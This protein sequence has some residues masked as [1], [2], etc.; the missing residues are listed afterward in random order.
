VSRTVCVIDSG[1]TVR[2]G[3]SVV[4]DIS[5]RFGVSVVFDISV[6]FGKSDVF[7]ISVRF[8][9][10]GRT[11]VSDRVS[12]SNRFGELVRCDSRLN[13][14]GGVTGIVIKVDT[15]GDIL[16]SKY[17]LVVFDDTSE[18]IINGD[19]GGGGGIYDVLYIDMS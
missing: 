14:G 17:I 10:S 12:I 16:G 11:S 13:D 4:F 6:R 19:G 1:V 3:D 5:V 18:P 8:G 7:D 15:G 9:D 2:F